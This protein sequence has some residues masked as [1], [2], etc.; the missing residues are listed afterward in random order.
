MD[1]FPVAAEACQDIPPWPVKQRLVNRRAEAQ[2]I[3]EDRSANQT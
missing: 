3:S 1:F 2:N